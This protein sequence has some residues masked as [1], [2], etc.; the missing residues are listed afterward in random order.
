MAL[1]P[2][3]LWMLLRWRVACAPC[4][5]RSPTSRSTP[6]AS[7]STT[8]WRT[9]CAIE[10]CLEILSEASRDVPPEAKA[11]HPEIPWRG[12]TDFDNVL[13]HDDPSVKDRRVWKIV[14]N[15]LTPLKAA[16]E[17]L[18]CDVDA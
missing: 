12:V 17:S 4:S 14:I 1:P 13:R 3:L 15:E 7:P 10:R 8:T 9:T 5:K 6:Q 11:H 16:V 18:L 2:A